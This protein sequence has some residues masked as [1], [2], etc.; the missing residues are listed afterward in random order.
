VPEG[1]RVAQLVESGVGESSLA[2]PEVEEDFDHGAAFQ[3][4]D[5][6]M[7]TFVVDEVVVESL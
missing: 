1:L 2:R 7:G 3:P 4:G 6:R 5:H